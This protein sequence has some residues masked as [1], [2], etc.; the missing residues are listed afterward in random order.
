MSMRLTRLDEQPHDVNIYADDD[1]FCKL[2][3]P[4]KAGTYLPQHA[5]EY[6]H[7]TLLLV[8]S[9]DIQVNDGPL[10]RHHA[11]KAIP[12]RAGTKHLFKA[13]VDGTMVACV[14]NLHGKGYPAVR[15]EHKLT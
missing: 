2:M 12:I 15:D 14:H 3:G 4:L 1:L 10:V 8:G 9:V 11:P 5:H 7:V 6:D 13:L